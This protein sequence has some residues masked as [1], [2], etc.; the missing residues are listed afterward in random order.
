MWHDTLGCQGA[1]ASDGKGTRPRLNHFTS[2]STKSLNPRFG[3]R[4][5]SQKLTLHCFF[6]TTDHNNNNNDPC[7]AFFANH[8]LIAFYYLSAFCVIIM[9]LV[10][11]ILNVTKAGNPSKPQKKSRQANSLCVVYKGCCSG[12]YACCY[13]NSLKKYIFKN[14]LGLLFASTQHLFFH[15][16][17]GFGTS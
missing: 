6:K 12:E 11:G 5:W 13:Y 9:K 10:S 2:C 8:R 3:L 16:S 1:A 4:K 14:Y 7:T 17:S 15:L